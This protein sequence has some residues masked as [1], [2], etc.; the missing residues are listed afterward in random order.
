MWNKWKDALIEVFNEKT[1]LS[2]PMGDG[3]TRK[4]IKITNGG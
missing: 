1:T 4:T 2:A 3:L